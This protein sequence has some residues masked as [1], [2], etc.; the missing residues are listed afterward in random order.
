MIA[1]LL[2]SS[3]CLL[4]ACNSGLAYEEY[5]YDLEE[6]IN[7]G[8]LDRIEISKNEVDTAVT[9]RMYTLLWQNELYT[10][11]SEGGKAQTYDKLTVDYTCEVDGLKID[12]FGKKDAAVVIG[13]ET[14]IDGMEEGLIG[15]A[16]G[17]QPRALELTFPDEYYSDLGGKKAIFTVTLKKLQRPHEMT[18]EIIT[19]YT[20]FESVQ[21]MRDELTEYFASEMAFAKVYEQAQVIKYPEAEYNAFHDDVLYL[22]TYAQEQKMTVEQFLA[23]Y[24]DQFSEYGFRNGM[25]DAEYRT[26]C[27][28]YAENMTKEQ[29]LI[30]YLLRELD[31]E[32]SGSV[33]D[34]KKESILRDTNM[35]DVANYDD[36]YG[37]GAF[38]RTIKYNLMLSALYE[39]VVLS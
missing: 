10:D 32:T 11:V 28:E 33:Y 20:N 30:Y 4:T 7:V 25:T 26:A 31:A 16:V 22:E 27:K 9:N 3:I 15:M 1:M 38:N 21:N 36:V 18:D 35:S 37:E 2:L 19:K 12:A 13:S 23:K 34:E 5:D 24:G 8:S 14:M 39:I 17:D 29:M 6:Y